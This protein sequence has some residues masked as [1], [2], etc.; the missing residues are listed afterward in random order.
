MALRPSTPGADIP[1][2]IRRSP[3]EVVTHLNTELHDAHHLVTL[4][5][6]RWTAKNNLVVTARPDTSAYQLTQA[7]HFISDILSIFLSH[8]S[9]PLPITS[10][11]NVKWS[12]LLI[13][14]IPTGVSSSR[15]PYSPSECQQVLMADNP[16]FWT[17]RLT[18]PPS[19]VR[20][21]STYGPGSIS[22]LVVAFKDPSGESLRSLLGGENPLRLQALW[23]VEM[24]E[25]EALQQGCDFLIWLILPTLTPPSAFLS[26]AANLALLK[27]ASTGWCL[28]W[29]P[30]WAFG[31]TAL[32][33]MDP[34]YPFVFI[35]S[36]T[37]FF[38]GQLFFHCRPPLSHHC[39]CGGPS[40]S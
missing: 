20:A 35:Y 14:G 2:V 21:P 5:A 12:Q 32:G 29:C 33:P 28:F 6:A 24:L 19:W 13:N 25:A 22:S 37:P 3:Q 17:L 38:P 7:S 26:W 9:S 23:G 18:Q 16:A 11:E 31:F 40:L 39:P 36:H 27:P 1:L 30:V 8:D 10:H 34:L 4:S 15:G